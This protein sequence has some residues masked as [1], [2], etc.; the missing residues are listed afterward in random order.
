MKND[1]ESN[2]NISHLVLPQTHSVSSLTAYSG[3]HFISIR[4]RKPTA[5]LNKVLANFIYTKNVFMHRKKKSTQ[6]QKTK[7]K[8]M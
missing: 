3:T 5:I 6:T 8:L 1:F 4:F 2:L 7:L